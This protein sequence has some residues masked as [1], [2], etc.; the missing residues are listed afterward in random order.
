MKT[1][2]TFAILAAVAACGLANAQT[3]YTTPVGYTTQT[4]PANKTTPVGFNVLS[5]TLVSGVLTGVTNANT[6]LTD[7]A[8]D[9]SSALTAG[10]T[11]TIDIK[12]GPGT[13]DGAVQDFITWSG[14]S[15]TVPAM[16]GVAVGDKYVIRAVPTLQE[17][18]PVGFLTGAT[19]A[20]N[21]DK[22]WVPNGSGGYNKYY[23]RIT[24]APTGWRK[25]TT[26][27]N[28]TG[29]APANIPLVYVDGILIEKKGTAK[30]L[31]L[32]GEVKTTGSN[33]V[34]ATGLNPM[35]IV[36]PAGLTLQTSGLQ[37]D[38]ASATSATNAD[39]VWVPNGT[40]GYTKYYHRIT[41]APTGWRTTT[42]GSNDTGAAP[43]NLPLEG[44]VIIER[45]G[46]AKVI[47]M[48]VPSSYSN[49]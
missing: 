43:L 47:S 46:V 39:K 41:I 29:A 23:Y 5:P 25:T 6:T 38:I 45:K 28:D 42:T 37:G 17:T 48:D 27:S 49:L 33:N 18:F 35:S 2:F 15:I 9:F 26:G 32:T 8:V 36:A 12:D 24:I 10:K 4:L 1:Q 19:S 31:V 40:G 30:S 22:V 16:A 13:I 44:A 7:T 21:A 14:S 34:L 20:A 11:Y 3:A